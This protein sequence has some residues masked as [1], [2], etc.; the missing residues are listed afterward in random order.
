MEKTQ[1]YIPEWLALSKE[2]RTKLAE[3][4]NLHRDVATEVAANQVMCDGYSNDML[5]NMNDTALAEKGFEGKDYLDSF[6]MLLKSLEVEPE[7]KFVET[8]EIEYVGT[9]TM[10]SAKEAAKVFAEENN[11]VEPV[12]EVKEE[13]IK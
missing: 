3:M 6:S 11:L 12:E 2:V 10:E 13:L 5:K 8:P 7:N 1:L 4:F 9:I